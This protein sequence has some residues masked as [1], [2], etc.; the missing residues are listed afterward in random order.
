MVKQGDLVKINFNPQ[1]GHEQAGY[2]PAVV[3]SNNFF[4]Q[5]TNLVIVC[6][7]TNTN[8]KFPLHIPLD[9]RTKTTGVVLCEHIK[10]LDLNA[11]EHK[12]VEQIPKDI[13]EKILDIVFSEIEIFDEES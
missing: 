3:I 12:V 9:E 8:N 2:R 10:A 1:A 5:K 6:P 7:I 11:R 13:L 4:N